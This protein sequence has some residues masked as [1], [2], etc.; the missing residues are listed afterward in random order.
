[1]TASPV[2]VDAGVEADVRAVVAGDDGAGVV[3]QVDGLGW[4][5]LAWYGG[6]GL[7]LDPLEAVLR[8]ARRAA[9]GDASWYLLV[10]HP[11]ILTEG[12]G[13]TTVRLE[14]GSVVKSGRI[15]GHARD[16][17]RNR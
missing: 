14:R 2:R 8:V 1:M 10:P 4:W 15:Q 6:V 11:W 7:N 16:C 5:L 17:G 12:Y 9:P 13:Y 3:A